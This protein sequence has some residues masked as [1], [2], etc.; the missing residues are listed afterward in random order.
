MDQPIQIQRKVVTS[1]GAGGQSETWATVYSV[2]AAVRAKSAREGLDQGR[3]NATYVVAFTI[4]TIADLTEADRIL[5]N[6]ETYN[7]RGILRSGS[8]QTV[9]VEGERGVAT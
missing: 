6:D 5:W 8:P 9:Q 4:Y 2:W 7:I 3:M 1:D